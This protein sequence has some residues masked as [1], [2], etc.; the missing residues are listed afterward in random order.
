MPSAQS[1]PLARVVSTSLANASWA[2]AVSPSRVAAS[3]SSTSASHGS[4]PITG[5]RCRA[6]SLDASASA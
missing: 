4:T 2:A 5:G 6:S 3:I 1:V